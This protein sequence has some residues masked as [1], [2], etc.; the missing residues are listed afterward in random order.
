[1]LSITSDLSTIYLC[2]IKETLQLQLKG[3]TDLIVR[4][5]YVHQGTEE[6][7]QRS[8]VIMTTMLW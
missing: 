1:M 6:R 8:R 2:L 3:G 7:H 5:T 4:P